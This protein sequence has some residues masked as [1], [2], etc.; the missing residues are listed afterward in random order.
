MKNMMEGQ[1]H[2]E[3]LL[4][5]HIGVMQ[6]RPKNPE[7]NLSAGKTDCHKFKLEYERL[8]FLNDWETDEEKI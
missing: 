1:T 3:R 8:C 6:D 5:K 4:L 7:F 2:N